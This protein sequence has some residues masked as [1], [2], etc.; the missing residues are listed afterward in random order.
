MTVKPFAS[1]STFLC[2]I[3]IFLLWPSSGWALHPQKKI[4]QYIQDTWKLEEGLPQMTVQTVI[5][6]RQGYLWLGTQEGLVRFDGIQFKTFT[7]AN[8]AQ[9]LNDWIW[10]LYQDREGNL[11]IGTDGGGLTCL[12]NGK[13]ITFNGKDGLSNDTVRCIHEDHEG[14]LWVGTE[15]GLN[16]LEGGKFSAV[17]REQGL[18]GER[19]KCLLEDRAGSLWI[20]TDGAG[21][22]RLRQG[23]LSVYT[24]KDG[25]GDDRI[26]ALSEDRAGN[27]W[28]GT[29]YGGLNKLENG[30]FSLYTTKNGL[31]ANRINC[32]YEDRDGPLWI[33]TYGGGLNRLYQG[34]FTAYTVKEGLSDDFVLSL[35]QDPEGSLWIGTGGGGL[36]RLQEGKFTPYTTR[37][38]LSD[39]LVSSI[40]EDREGNLWIG[41]YGGGLNRFKDGTFT[42]YTTAQGLSNNLVRSLYE[43]S[44]GN[45]WVGTDNGLNRWKDGKF[46]VFTGKQGLSNERIWCLRE[47]RQGALWIGTDDGLNRWQDG[48]FTVFTKKQGLSHEKIMCIREDKQGD[49]WIGTNGGGL[50]RRRGKVFTAYTT[51]QGL[52]DN[53]VWAIHE[54]QE[55]TLWIGTRG[56]GLNRLKNGRFTYFTMKE[57]LFND[58]VYQ[59][60]EDDSGNL[61][62]SCNKGI[63]K[64]SKKEFDDFAAG[65]SRRIHPVSYNEEDGLKSRECMGGTQPPGCKTRDGKLWFP[66]LK[67]AVMIDPTRIKLNPLPPPLSIE[68][69]TAGTLRIPPPFL[70]AKQPM[71]LPAGTERLEIQY[72]GLSLLVPER[73]RFKFLLD[74]VD[75]DWLEVGTRRTAYYTKLSPGNYT[76]RVTACNNDGVWNRSGVSLWLYLKPYFYQTVWFGLLCGLVVV[77]LGFLGYRGLVRQYKA[78]ENKLRRL[79][80]ERTKALRE[81][82]LQLENKVKER[83]S[84]LL[85]ANQ[86][87]NEAKESAEQANR[88]KSMFLANMSHEIRTPM[89]AILGFS[90]ILGKETASQ[91]H[92]H[93]LEA[94]STG[95]RRLLGL[96]DDIL[97]LSKIEAGKI[98]FHPE[99]VSPLDI[100]NEFT[101][102]F[103]TRVKEKGVDFRVETDPALPEFVMMDKLRLRQI[104][105]N[106]VENAVKFT[107]SGFIHLSAQRGPG[108]AGSNPGTQGKPGTIES[109]ELIFSVQDSGIGIPPDQLHYIFETFG[110]VERQR[111]PEYGGTGL[112][113]T[114]SQ[115]LTE[116]MGGEISLR[117]QEG[118]GTTVTVIFKRIGVASQPKSSQVEMETT[119]APAVDLA[120]LRFEPATVLVADDQELGRQLLL[121][122]LDFFPELQ[123]LEAEN[124]QEALDL[125]RIHTPHLVLM[126]LEMPLMDGYEAIRRFKAD[127]TLQA[128]PIIAVTGFDLEEQQAQVEE[129]GGDGYLEK[130]ISHENLAVQLVR[131]LPHSSLYKTLPTEEPTT[132]REKSPLTGSLT[133]ELLDTLPGLLKILENR[134][135]QRWESL[136]QTFFLDEIH[137]FSTDLRTLGQQYPPGLLKNWADK[138]ANEIERYDMQQVTKTLGEFPGL[139]EKIKGLLEHKDE[140]S[141]RK[142]SR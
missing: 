96:I 138:L 87:L 133:P 141:E 7:K 66:T 111:S 139:V 137:R 9:L 10:T 25:I 53:R 77:G 61:W 65:K 112:G 46:T 22:Y 100:L 12:K 51:R 68:C 85:R 98:Q 35:C 93:L 48:E 32:I 128:I 45:L 73:V 86:R 108:S 140:K 11:W 23:K 127:E 74:G 88:A 80:E 124:G 4:T 1:L 109:I 15:N 99:A 81:L 90:Q 49:L 83:T 121:E 84:E 120:S 78:R 14:K 89:N 19:I 130:P 13:F 125:A 126:D 57:G 72:T 24:S 39:N 132:S 44:R 129:A 135:T 40:F 134:F 95:G 63:F 28:I 31:S 20:G 58:I 64:V 116:R 110:Q 92:K 30:E 62:M 54:D 59:I 114:I 107:D 106:L 3:L 43:D 123:V 38:G 76:F 97:D 50:I 55:G 103:S 142:K 113:L 101:H 118:K 29:D 67:G 122:Y 41:T 69:V 21:L 16:V 131:F 2:L 75:R 119:V 102:I 79:V 82:N 33:G 71:I 52:S 105:F 60:L 115:H 6:S 17:G 47:D 36:N 56:G 117:S 136:S 104:L 5:R 26:N 37:E 42:A 27:L 8:V 91:R 18:N 34:K 94:I 70:S